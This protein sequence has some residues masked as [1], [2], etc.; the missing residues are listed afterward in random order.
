M[1]GPDGPYIVV[2]HPGDFL[3]IYG[4]LD[5][6]SVTLRRKT[7]VVRGQ[8]LG[9]MGSSRGDAGPWLHFELRYNNQGANAASVLDAID[10]GGR[11][12]QDYKAGA[13][14]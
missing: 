3:T 14:Y 2:E 6:E 4:H 1:C 10:L 8:P 7:A 13:V 5:A 9:R 11:T 12:F